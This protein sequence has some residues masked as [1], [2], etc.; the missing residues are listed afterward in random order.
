MKLGT[1]GSGPTIPRFVAR[2][3]RSPC[4]DL[5]CLVRGGAGLRPVLLPSPDADARGPPCDGPRLFAIAA[6]R[7]VSRPGEREPRLFFFGA[8]L[9]VIS[10]GR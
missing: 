9:L 3:G 2:A 8:T 7:V 6:D 10:S 1:P 5:R 4:R